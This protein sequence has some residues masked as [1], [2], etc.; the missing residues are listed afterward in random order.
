MHPTLRAGD[1][2][3]CL[4]WWRYRPGQLVVVKGEDGPMIKR[5]EA[6]SAR[7]LWL[8]GD[9]RARSTDSRELGWIPHHHIHGR[10]IYRYAPAERVGWLWQ[11]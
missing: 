5:I 1:R 11:A 10:V 4:P 8:L 7:G 3:L 9:N 2:V 6:V